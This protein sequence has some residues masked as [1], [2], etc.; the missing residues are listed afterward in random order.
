MP[1]EFLWRQGLAFESCNAV[2]SVI[3]IRKLGMQLEGI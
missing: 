1:H 3:L 2:K